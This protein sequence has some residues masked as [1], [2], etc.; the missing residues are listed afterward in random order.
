[1]SRFRY[2]NSTENIVTIEYRNTNCIE[3]LDVLFFVKG[4]ALTL[5]LRRLFKQYVGIPQNRLTGI[6]GS[7]T[8]FSASVLQE[9]KIITIV[10]NGS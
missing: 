10:L 6:L 9:V 3:T 1:M 2:T 4:V 8:S 7:A 5:N